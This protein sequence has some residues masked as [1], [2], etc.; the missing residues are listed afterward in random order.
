ML[1][2]VNSKWEQRVYKRSPPKA[3]PTETIYTTAS[4]EFGGEQIDYGYL[5]QAHTD[6]DI[7]VYFR[8]ANVM[9]AGDVV[10]VGEYPVIDYCTGGWIGGMANA[11]KSLLDISN[12]DTRIVPGRGPVQSRADLQAE[13]DMLAALKTKLSRLLADGMSV[14]D[15][16]DAAPTREYDAKW[17]DPRLF[18]ANTW[19]GL[20]Q[21][22]RELGVLI[23]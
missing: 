20:V 17:G 22:A 16:L 10:S 13:N 11:T 2:N 18:I 5:P 23:V 12:T 19:Q 1:K 9:V 3:L 4:L 7:Y 8:K 15:M 6:G 21:R 14:Q